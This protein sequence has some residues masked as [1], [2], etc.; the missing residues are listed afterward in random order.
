MSKIKSTTDEKEKI[1]FK[2]ANKLWQ[3][4]G[5]LTLKQK[6]LQLRSE[7]QGLLRDATTYN[8]IGIGYYDTLIRT[9]F[10][11][12]YSELQK[13]IKEGKLTEKDADNAFSSVIAYINNKLDEALKILE[14]KYSAKKC[15]R[16]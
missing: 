13:M 16:L 4:T 1:M 7:A 6:V 12:F 11:V 5:N 9:D 3:K 2:I 8:T 14:Q 10:A 15:E